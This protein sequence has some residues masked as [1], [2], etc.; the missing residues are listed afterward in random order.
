MLHLSENPFGD[1]SATAARSIMVCSKQKVLYTYFADSFVKIAFV[2]QAPSPLVTHN[3]QQDDHL[4]DL[5][6]NTV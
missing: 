3:A 2:R 5:L 4:P 6:K 1:L